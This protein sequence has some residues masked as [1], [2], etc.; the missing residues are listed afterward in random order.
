MKKINLSITGCNGRMGQQLIKTIKKDKRFTL[1]SVTE[2]KKIKKKIAGKKIQFNSEDAFKKLLTID[3][4]IPKCTL[5]VLKIAS[6]L[7]KRVVIGT[8]G[9]TKNDENLIKTYAKKSQF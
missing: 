8:S 1:Y 7:N 5:N 4:T 9:F 3:F 2:F 6:K